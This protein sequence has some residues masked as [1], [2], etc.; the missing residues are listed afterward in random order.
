MQNSGYPI[1]D[2]R[3]YYISEDKTKIFSVASYFYTRDMMLKNSYNPHKFIPLKSIYF[4]YGKEHKNFDNYED[5]LS[6][7]IYDDYKSIKPRPLSIAEYMVLVAKNSI[8]LLFDGERYFVRARR[9]MIKVFLH[10]WGEMPVDIPRHFIV[11][12]LNTLKNFSNIIANGDYASIK[13]MLNDWSKSIGTSQF[14]S[15]FS[16]H[17]YDFSQI[18]PKKEFEDLLRKFKKAEGKVHWHYSNIRQL[19]KLYSLL[20]KLKSVSGTLDQ[21]NY[22][23]VLKYLLI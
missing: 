2:L 8:T 22:L 13:S 16:K 7:V 11:S 14:L 15:I 12:L 3:A 20:I 17:K 4:I 18:M 1:L 19:H 9:L 23:N 21:Y 5:I 6:Q 10:K